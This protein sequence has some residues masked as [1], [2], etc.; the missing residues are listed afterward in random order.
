VRHSLAGIFPY[1]DVLG[2]NHL[3]A[4]PG[5]LGLLPLW[6]TGEIEIHRG[7]L[8]TWLL[9]K[10]FL[11]KKERLKIK[12]ND[13]ISNVMAALTTRSEDNFTRRTVENIVCKVFRRY[14]KTNSD[15]LFHDIL[16]PNQSIYSVNLNKVRKM[17][18]DGISIKNSKHPLLNM[19]PF[20]GRYISLVDLHS[21]CTECY[22]L[23]DRVY[24][25]CTFRDGTGA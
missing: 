6:V 25:G 3:V 2:G 17:S 23:K 19:V 1:V 11:D 22:I 24:L 5:T 14:T 15:A 21:K 16:L 4:I 8:I 10:F 7:R 13:V 12:V 18:A 9:T 20:Q